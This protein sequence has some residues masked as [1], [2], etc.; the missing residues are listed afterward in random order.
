ME[1]AGK[2]GGGAGLER[3][4]EIVRLSSETQPSVIQDRG[5][6]DTPE[7]PVS[8]PPQ[9]CPADTWC[10]LQSRVTGQCGPSIP[11]QPCF[12]KFHA[13]PA[14]TLCR[15]CCE[16]EWEAACMARLWLSL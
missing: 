7:K 8:V 16:R 15:Q 12:Y 4:W 5:D 10:F 1:G 11:A 6:M 13:V 9:G 14:R 3:T 2:S